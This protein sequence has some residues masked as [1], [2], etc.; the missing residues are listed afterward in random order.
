MTGTEENEC[1]EKPLG[2]SSVD[3]SFIHDLWLVYCLLKEAEEH[4]GSEA[5]ILGDAREK[6]GHIINR[7]YR[8]F[9]L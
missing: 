2:A 5:N 9:H 6:L 3:T 1:R 4:A 7:L 8:L